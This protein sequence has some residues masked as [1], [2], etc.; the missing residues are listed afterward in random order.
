MVKVIAGADEEPSPDPSSR[1]RR[2]TG[3]SV[4]VVSAG[5]SE[6]GDS[7]A[8]GPEAG[9]P[10]A[11]GPE[12]GDS[13]AGGPEAGGPE[14]GDSEPGDSEP[15]DPEPGDSEPGDSEP[16]DSEPGDSE[17][18]DS[19]PGDSEPGDPEPGDSEPGDSEPGDSEPG[20]SEPG[21][22]LWK[23]AVSVTE[24]LTRTEAGAVKVMPGARAATGPSPTT[25]PRRSSRTAPAHTIL[26]LDSTVRQRP[27]GRAVGSGPRLIPG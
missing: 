19:E 15:G 1:A 13:E 5:D 20:D 26:V 24:L 6:A 12:A 18:G 11:G 16:G 3:G 27:A 2:M 17:P 25:R 23:A 21:G 7:E 22:S 14:P 10:E 8:G 9:G 4:V